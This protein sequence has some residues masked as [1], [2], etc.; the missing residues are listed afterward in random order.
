MEVAR[1][2]NDEESNLQIQSSKGRI[3]D[4][5]AAYMVNSCQRK[6]AGVILCLD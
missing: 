3:L 4:T 6:V 5:I 1:L 2:V